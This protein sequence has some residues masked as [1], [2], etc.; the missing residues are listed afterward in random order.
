[1]SVRSPPRFA[2]ACTSHF[3]W[4]HSAP[5]KGA[6]T[7]AWRR[8]R[9]LTERW[10]RRHAYAAVLPTAACRVPASSLRK[11]SSTS[12]FSA[13]PWQASRLIFATVLEETFRCVCNLGNL[14][15]CTVVPYLRHVAQQL[16]RCT[17]RHSRCKR[18]DYLGARIMSGA[19]L[20]TNCWRY[21]CVQHE[22]GE[23]GWRQVSSHFSYP[24]IRSLGKS[25]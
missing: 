8:Q 25:T 11:A 3:S 9:L 12:P 5:K 14:A 19:L 16:R 6:S 1:L 18:E 4:W 21:L 20:P 13:C 15:I 22:R 24:K 2:R 23:L 17:L 10:Q 7:R